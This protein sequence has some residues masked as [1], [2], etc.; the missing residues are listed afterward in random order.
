[1]KIILIHLKMKRIIISIPSLYV[2]SRNTQ[3]GKKEEESL[4]SMDVVVVKHCEDEIIE[5]VQ[6]AEVKKV[7]SE[8]MRKKETKKKVDVF[9]PFPQVKSIK[10]EPEDTKSIDNLMGLLQNLD[11]DKIEKISK[12]LDLLE[13]NKQTPEII[14]TLPKEMPVV[15]PLQDKGKPKKMQLPK[16][17]EL[18]IRIISTWGNPH[19]AGLTEIEIFDKDGT[20]VSTT[21][22]ARNLGNG[23]SQPT[24]KLT[25]GKI[26]T[27]EEKFMWIAYIPFA[28]KYLELVAILPTTITPGGIAIWNYNKSANDSVKGVRK[29]EIL[30]NGS[31]KWSGLIKRGNGR[32]NED[33]STEINLCDN[34]E[35]FKDKTKLSEALDIEEMPNDLQQL[36]RKIE[37][38][39]SRPISVPVSLQRHPEEKKQIAKQ[40]TK[41]R[42]ESNTTVDTASKISQEKNLKIP[43]S[44]LNPK[45]IFGGK[46]SKI[47]QRE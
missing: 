43:G 2:I 15:T 18:V 35:V 45:A 1:M 5:E 23:P 36:K 28:P 47:R 31:L 11:N 42:T 37:E 26:Y 40:G 13:E 4:S 22:K 30:I 21:F 24:S 33:Y 17:Q 32:K 44:K 7:E 16:K 27:D 46:T 25:N 12:A 10:K 20:R 39:G 14:K 9:R 19:V 38:S 6:K 41:V 3:F 8:E 34:K 29:A